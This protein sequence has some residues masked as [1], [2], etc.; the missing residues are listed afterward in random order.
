[1]NA[2]MIASGKVKAPLAGKYP[3]LSDTSSDKLKRSLA[4]EN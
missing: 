4:S 1:M 3:V 2:G